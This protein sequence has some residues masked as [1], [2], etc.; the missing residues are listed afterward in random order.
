MKYPAAKPKKT[1][2]G[3]GGLGV[4]CVAIALVWGVLLPRLSQMPTNENYIR[5]LQARRIDPSAMYYTELECMD[6]VLESL[7]VR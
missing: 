1:H 5:F 7:N 4:C 3:I 6:E 2:A